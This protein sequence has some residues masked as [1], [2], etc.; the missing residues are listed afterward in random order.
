MKEK[1]YFCDRVEKLGL[2]KIVQI[3]AISSILIISVC[4]GV[5]CI[6]MHMDLTKNE[7]KQEEYK[8]EYAEDTI[9]DSIDDATQEEN[10]QYFKETSEVD[11]TVFMYIIAVCVGIQYGS[12][13]IMA[14][15]VGTFIIYAI[16]II[17]KNFHEN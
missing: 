9:Y 7:L 5:I 11:V 8:T 10:I 13:F 16:S 12:L 4:V 17:N 1:R 3:V 6:I 2:R 15:I 14:L